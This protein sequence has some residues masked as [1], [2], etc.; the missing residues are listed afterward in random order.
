[1]KDASSDISHPDTKGF[2]VSVRYAGFLVM[3]RMLLCCIHPKLRAA[4]LRLFGAKVGSNVRVYEA[5]FINLQSGFRNLHIDEDVHIGFGCLFDLAAPIRIGKR[6]TI[7]PRVTIMSHSDAGAAHHSALALRYKAE[8]RAVTIGAD[9]WIG[10]SAVI[11]SGVTIADLCV[12]AA[13]SVVTNDIPSGN[14]AAGVPATIKC[15]IKP[16]LEDGV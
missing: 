13:G 12:V 15:A 6:S 14:V 2:L 10:T 5:R 1:M 3:E 9:C 4:L 16:N 11:L 7:S 8:V